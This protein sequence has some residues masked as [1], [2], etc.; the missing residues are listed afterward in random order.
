MLQEWGQHVGGEFESNQSVGLM[1]NCMS[2]ARRVTVWGAR[3]R[4]GEA[5]NPGP[6]D[7]DEGATQLDS[8]VTEFGT[9][10]AALEFELTKIL[11]P[12]Q[13]P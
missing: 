6:Q 11:R 5:K 3:V 13:T 7:R 4:V 10:V 1:H 9:Q 2:T 12:R 8:G